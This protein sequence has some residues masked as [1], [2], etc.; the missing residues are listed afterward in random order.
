L[1]GF[2]REDGT[3]IFAHVVASDRASNLQCRYIWR[4]QPVAG[5]GNTGGRN[6]RALRPSFAVGQWIVSASIGDESGA[7]FAS[8]GRGIHCPESVTRWL[9]ITASDAAQTRCSN[10]PVTT[11]LGVSNVIIQPLGSSATPALAMPAD[12]SSGQCAISSPP[13]GVTS[14][15]GCARESPGAPFIDFI[16]SSREFIVCGA[17]FSSGPT[18]RRLELDTAGSA[19][20]AVLVATATEP[21]APQVLPAY[22]DPAEERHARR[23]AQSATMCPG[24]AGSATITLPNN[25]EAL[26]AVVPR[27]AAYFVIYLTADHDVDTKLRTADASSAYCLAGAQSCRYGSGT[28]TCPF[29]M[30]ELLNG[31]HRTDRCDG[32]EHSGMNITFTGDDVLAPVREVLEISNTVANTLYYR[33]RSRQQGTFTA[34]WDYGDYPASAES[35]CNGPVVIVPPRPPSPPP[36]P[37]PSPP[38]PPMPRPPEPP[39]Y[40]GRVTSRRLQ[41]SAASS[42][43]TMQLPLTTSQGRVNNSALMESGELA[44]DTQTITAADTGGHQHVRITHLRVDLTIT[45]AELG[46]QPLFW[47][48]VAIGLLNNET[49]CEISWGGVPP[50]RLGNYNGNLGNLRGHALPSAAFASTGHYAFDPTSIGSISSGVVSISSIIT[51]SI[52][53]V[54]AV[55]LKHAYAVDAHFSAVGLAVFTLEPAAAPQCSS[56]LSATTTNDYHTAF[57]YIVPAPT[58]PPPSPPSP[59]TPPSPPPYEPPPP[60]TPPLPPPLRPPSLPPGFAFNVSGGATS[61]QCH[62]FYTPTGLRSDCSIQFVRP[63]YQPPPQTPPPPPP[64]AQAL[65]YSYS[66]QYS[67]GGG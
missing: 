46:S 10:C 43:V 11:T 9:E 31:Y 35:P 22:T 51:L 24:S 33:V 39:W 16:P 61:R 58:P 65:G 25:D 45:G 19:G 34:T 6:T 1:Y 52:G 55:G 30:E 27:G 15:L 21:M 64:P 66:Y 42:Q 40:P 53:D 60:S 48:D 23:R 54:L 41:T 18:A 36:M 38:T 3:S 44:V 63:V 17:C 56:G 20:S 2:A 13:T 28:Q 49:G 50:L 4:K 12:G 5:Q 14:F 47:Q 37:P 29:R 62:L 8:D 7:V 57:A 32:G 67:Y 26:V 59:P